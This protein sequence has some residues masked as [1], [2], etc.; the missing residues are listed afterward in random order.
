MRKL[1]LVGAEDL[2]CVQLYRFPAEHRD[3]N[4]RNSTFGG[5]STVVRNKSPRLEEFILRF[6]YFGTLTVFFI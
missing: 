6:I 5:Y 1:F 2:D 4:S 3:D